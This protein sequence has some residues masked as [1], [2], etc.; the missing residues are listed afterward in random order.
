[1]AYRD[2]A[3]RNLLPEKDAKVVL[4][5]L[6]ETL[7]VAREQLSDDARLTDDL[8]ADSLDDVE[9]M[10]A[11]EERLGITVTDEQAGN[12]KTV[13]ELFELISDLSGRRNEFS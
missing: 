4:E 1:M 9:I 13:G 3:M 7:G 11:V 2:R 5:I 8:G 10:M 6:E 12:V